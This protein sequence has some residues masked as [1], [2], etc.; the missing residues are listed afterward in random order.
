MSGSHPQR[1][2]GGFFRRWWGRRDEGATQESV[3][4]DRFDPA[5]LKEIGQ[6]IGE[7]TASTESVAQA[8]AS[9]GRV[10]YEL[11]DSVTRAA[12]GAAEQTRLIEDCLNVIRALSESAHQ[13]SVGAQNQASAISKASHVVGQMV[14]TMEKVTN[15]T[16][17]VASAANQ[18]AGFATES[19]DS[20]QHV[21]RG[22]DK[23]RETVFAAGAK[24]RDFSSQSDQIAGIVQVISELAEQTNLLALNAAIEAARAG[25]Q[26]RGFAV[27]ADEVRKLAER[28][29]K[30]AE[31]IAGLIGK[32]QRALEEVQRTMEA[33]TDEVRRG[34][35]LAARAGQSMGQVV[36][37]VED[38]RGQIQEILANTEKMSAGSSEMTHVMNE[39][40]GVAEENSATTEEM[41]AS[42]N[43]AVRLIQQVANITRKVS[44]GEVSH[45]AQHQAGVIDQIAASAT[46]LSDEVKALKQLLEAVTAEG[47][48]SRQ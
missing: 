16:K 2:A 40:A 27:V 25:E 6:R 39:I 22:M 34:T 3:I 33:G 23:I 12:Q 4:Y 46:S 31:E 11:A 8:S 37:I 30:A 9:A 29:K 32:S 10:N 26:G 19:G 13:I 42:T 14:A 15:S 1:R 18:A 5:L 20:V 47:V 28:S 35:E 48:A 43:E 44:I 21:V 41:A 45:A 17:Q 24:V 36:R 38:T 7:L